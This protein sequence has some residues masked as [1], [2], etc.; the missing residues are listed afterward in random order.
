MQ[1]M[2][3][4][5]AFRIVHA[6]AAAA[7]AACAAAVQDRNLTQALLQECLMQLRRVLSS[8]AWRMLTLVN[9]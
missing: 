2:Q 4:M 7:I 6:A 9:M 1:Q 3:L 5:E 8:V